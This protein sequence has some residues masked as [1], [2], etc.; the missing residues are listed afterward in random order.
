MK[1]KAKLMRLEGLRPHPLQNVF[2]SGCSS[3]DDPALAESLRESG[4]QH[5]LVAAPMTNEDGTVGYLLLDGHRRLR[6]LQQ[7]GKSEA[8]VL[9]REDLA[10]AKPAEIEAEFLKYNFCRRQLKT[11]QKARAAKRLFELEKG[12]DFDRFSV[13]DHA[14][15]KTRI[16]I[17]LEMSGRNLDR[18]LR[19]L[20]TPTEIQNAVEDG[21]L[22][23]VLGAKVAML[24]ADQQKDLSERIAGVTDAG[25]VRRIAAQFNT[26]PAA[27]HRGVRAALDTF[28]R[29]LE[30]NLNDLESRSAEVSPYH[31]HRHIDV[32]RRAR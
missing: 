8:L 20:E 31:V 27:G 23:L 22:T 25:V 15:F 24:A 18:Y 29:D 11:I 26:P 28:A 9:V 2:Y 10:D 32:L 3:E 30:K 12:K 17:V 13:W 21:R 19:L 5:P 7:M 1:N 6:L 16:G 14:D 4:L